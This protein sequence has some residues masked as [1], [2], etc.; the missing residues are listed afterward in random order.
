MAAK[1]IDELFGQALDK[2]RNERE[3]QQNL[4]DSRPSALE[5]EFERLKDEARALKQ[6]LQNHPRFNY[7]WIF[8]DQITI[9]F[10]TGPNQPTVQLVVRLYHPGN[11]RFKQGIYGYLPCG[12][13]MLLDSVDEAIEFIATQCGK[14]LA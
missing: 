3:R 10:R 12:Y 2:F 1:R 5:R 11:N 14:L 7:F 13:E 4:D 8:R 6:H 9:S